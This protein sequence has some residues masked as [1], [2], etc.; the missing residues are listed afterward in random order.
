M[1]ATTSVALLRSVNVAGRR[2][3]RMDELRDTFVALGFAEVTTYIQSGNVVFTSGD[4][5][6]AGVIERALAARFGMDVT[7]AVRT[8][9]ELADVLARNPHPDPAKVHVGFLRHEP[10]VAEPLDL[11]AYAPDDAVVDGT[12][13]Y[14]HL[15]NGIGRSKLPDLLGR[16]LQVPITV[17]NWNTVTKLAAMTSR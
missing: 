3:I 6:D 7:V 8:G 13:V 2:M 9:A 10:T 16:R 12:E 14:F 1:T 5:V 4:P 15:P 17:R 11:R